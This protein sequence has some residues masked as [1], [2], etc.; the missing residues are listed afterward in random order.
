MIST[1]LNFF[2]YILIFLLIFP[3]VGNA[4]QENLPLNRSYLLNIEKHLAHPGNSSHTAVKPYL[5]SL[6]NSDSIANSEN[7]IQKHRQFQSKFARKIKYESL[8]HVDTGDF[9]LHI[10]PL[11]NFSFH[12][13]NADVSLRADTSSFY[14]NSRGFRASGDITTKFSFETTFLE[15]QSFF[16]SYL[17]DYVQQWGVVPGQ[18]RVK[19]FK[20]SGYDYAW[21]SGNVSYSPIKNINLQLGHGN[22][23]I[24]EGYRSLILS[25][26]AFVYP[27]LKINTAFFK[28]RLNYTNIYS[29]LQTLIRMKTQVVSQREELFIRKQGT[30]HYLSF[31]ATKRLQ[32]GVFEGIIWK[33]S[34]N[35]YPQKVSPL[36]YN[37]VIFVNTVA[38]LN[39]TLNNVFT[40]INIKYKLLNK[41]TLYGQFLINGLKTNDYGWQAG[42]KTFD[43]F[44]IKNL[45][46]QSEFNSV[47][48]YTYSFQNPIQNYGHY[49]QSLAHPLGAGFKEFVGFI[50][51]GIKD[52]FLGVKFNYA[53]MN[54]DTSGYNNGGNIFLAQG[55]LSGTQL[56]D[57][58]LEASLFWKEISVGYIINRKTNMKIMVGFSE[59]ISAN[60]N[61]R[62]E[63]R[64]LF[65]ALRTDLFNRYYD[66]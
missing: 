25:D 15:N 30:F 42:F 20:K 54:Y 51:Y 5:G 62:Q 60:V 38:L 36:F 40:G 2:K 7:E 55:E 47:E 17:D 58:S 16:V 18:G 9:K 21:A 50:D 10:D 23:F 1:F 52:L 6:I 44:S 49:N 39:D 53:T 13:D 35:N 4:Q 37:P 28:N 29:S 43:L 33:A 24:G 31:N 57:K 56:P 41:T 27:Y 34:E 26:N 66:F 3:L 64:I 63:S 45:H 59:R 8:I 12:Q 48:P 32:I 19:E 22:H 14:T 11:F 46:L 61:R 65:F